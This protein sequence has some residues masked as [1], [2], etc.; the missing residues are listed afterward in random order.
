MRVGEY[1]DGEKEGYWVSYFANGNKMSE[2]EYR[3]GKKHGCG[4]SIIRTATNKAR[5]RLSRAN[6]PASIRLTMKTARGAG[7]AI[8]TRSQVAPRME[9]KRASGLR[10][11]KMARRYPGA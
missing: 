6:T 10:M 7:K 8:I 11:K 4:F 9:P 3:K 1:V 5:P 2:G